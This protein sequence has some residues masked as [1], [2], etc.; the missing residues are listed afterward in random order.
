MKILITGSAGFI[1]FHLMKSL[2][3]SNHIVFGVDNINDYYS[4]KLKKDRL[5]Q[6]GF[7]KEI[8]KNKLIKSSISNKLFFIRCDLKEDKTYKVL[9]KYKFDIIIHLAAQAGVQFSIKNPHTYVDNNITASIKLFDFSNSIKCKKII[10]ASTSSVYGSNK[11]TPFNEKDK[12]SSPISTYASTKLMC[13]N[14]SNVYNHLYNIKF[15]GLR[16]FTVYGPW[17]R[18]DMA[19]YKFIDH[20]FKK[21]PITVYEG[22][23]MIRDFTYI[24]DIVNG[25]NSTIVNFNKINKV[26]KNPIINLGCNN[27]ILLNNVVNFLVKDLNLKLKI[28]YKKKLKG[29]VDSTLADISL[30]K[31]YLNFNPMTQYQQGIRNLYEWYIKYNKIKL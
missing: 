31:K 18:P 17:G 1:G 20:Y 22:G 27:P 12:T 26:L 11:K 16:F 15:V 10:Y 28:K 25:I 6:I 5:K 21:K 2:I 9:S 19:I 7:N 4:S 13:E 23:K 8:F 24:D 14:L 3:I 30:A 29:D